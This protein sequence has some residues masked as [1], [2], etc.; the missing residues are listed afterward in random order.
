VGG[1]KD[2]VEWNAFV[3]D[4]YAIVHYAGRAKLLMLGTD[5]VPVAKNGKKTVGSVQ[6][7]RQKT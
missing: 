6:N 7:L 3:L 1:T 4:R 5:I 2:N